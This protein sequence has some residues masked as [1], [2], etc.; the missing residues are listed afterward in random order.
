MDKSQNFAGAMSED[1][2]N[3]ILLEQLPQVRYIARHIHD[4]LPQHV[5]LEDLVHAGVL[6]LIDALNKYD[7]AKEVQFK[8]YAEP[9][10]IASVNW[11]GVRAIC[12]GS[13]AL[14]RKRPHG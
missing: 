7:C 14:S 11:I 12:D 5:P 3:R 8:R 1:D 6:G 2:R 4:R 10:S 13:L 9:S